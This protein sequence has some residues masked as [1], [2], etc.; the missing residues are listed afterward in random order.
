LIPAFSS[1]LTKRGIQGRLPVNN[2]APH[3]TGMSSKLIILVYIK[4]EKSN[5]ILSSVAVLLKYFR[6][7][8]HWPRY[9]LRFSRYPFSLSIFAL[10]HTKPHFIVPAFQGM[11]YRFDVLYRK[12]YICC[13]HNQKKKNTFFP[14]W[15]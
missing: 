9:M 13:H 4:I 12:L 8:H 2:H 15:H 10:T 5:K 1:L 11:L 7:L 6:F 3:Q 14:F